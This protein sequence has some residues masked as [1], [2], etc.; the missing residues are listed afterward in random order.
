MACRGFV[1]GQVIGALELEVLAFFH[2]Q[3]SGRERYFQPRLTT[4]PPDNE[5]INAATSR[6]A[7]IGLVGIN[8]AWVPGDQ[9][10]P[11]GLTV[12]GHDYLRA[13]GRALAW[14][15]PVPRLAEFRTALLREQW[16][17]QP[18]H[19]VRVANTLLHEF[20]PRPTQ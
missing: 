4:P 13:L 7:S 8:R 14:P 9:G 11:V 12:Y 10:W 19:V 5:S 16:A 17:T 1:M 2:G 15:V 20:K 18:D 3:W 6:L